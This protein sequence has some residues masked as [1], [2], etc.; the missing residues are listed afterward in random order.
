[1]LI[2]LLFCLTAIAQTAP[3]TSTSGSTEQVV[4][5]NSAPQQSTIS[6]TAQ[7]S[8]PVTGH[9]GAVTRL[10]III[11]VIDTSG[12]VRRALPQLKQVARDILA[13]APDASRFGV[14]SVNTEAQKKMFA[15]RVDAIAYIDTLK[16]ARNGFTDL[17]RATDA[18]LTLI[19]GEGESRPTVIAYLTDGKLEVPDSFKDKSDFVTILGREFTPRSNIRVVVVSVN[20][21]ELPK[22]AQTLPQNVTFFP[23]TNWTMAQ[24][25]V[26]KTLVPQIR[27]QL[28]ATRAPA[29]PVKATPATA[30]PS[31]VLRP[32]LVMVAAGLLILL[33]A[34]GAFLAQQSRRRKRNEAEAAQALSEYGGPEN[35][36]TEADLQAAPPEPAPAQVALLEIERAAQHGLSDDLPAGRQRIKM[37]VGERVVIGN[38]AIAADLHFAELKQTQTLELRLEKDSTGLVLKA[39]RLRPDAPGALDPVSVNGQKAPMIFTLKH[40]DK[41]MVGPVGFRIVYADYRLLELLDGVGDIAPV[42]AALIDTE[43]TQPALR[44]EPPFAQTQLPPLFTPGEHVSLRRRYGS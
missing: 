3:P 37:E 7:T 27:E 16:A 14:I 44:D 33:L 5:Q 2:A 10:P 18:A 4:T 1:M 25:E 6:A 12:T 21:G 31:S 13:A 40:G 42:D 39:Y 9:D 36:L 32:R 17:N 26:A 41:F 22:G 34:G 29:E 15:Q 38:T 11:T 24:T 23:M 28:T 20:G 35:L 8:G 43:P 19:Q 30:A